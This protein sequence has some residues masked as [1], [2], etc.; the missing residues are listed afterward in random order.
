MVAFFKSIWNGI[1]NVFGSVGSWF[2]NVFG[3]AWQAVKNVFSNWGSFW[4]GLWSTISNTFSSGTN[5]ANAISG[6]VKAG[7]NGV[8]S[9]IEGTINSGISL[10][11]GAIGLINKIPGVEIG[12]L[13]MLSFPRLAR[14]GFALGNSLVE[15]GE[16]NKKEVVLP[17]ER[18]LGWADLMSKALLDGLKKEMVKTTA[19]PINGVSFERQLDS[20][21]VSNKADNIGVLIGLVSEWF[22][23]L[24]EASKH[25]IYLDGRTLVGETI[26]LIDESLALTYQ[27]KERGIY[28][29][30]G[31]KFGSY[32][33]GKT[34]V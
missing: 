26:D 7:I 16:Q 22:P 13:G 2:G 9:S 33:T 20:T 24:V 23:R 30:R 19:T 10:I 28:M 34:G 4:S 17:L 25:S 27:L 18:N 31:V 8:I 5:I 15:I 32:H 11:N 12:K 6:S 21:Y 14:G 1:K 3:K 29:L